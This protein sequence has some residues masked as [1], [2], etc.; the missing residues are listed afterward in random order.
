VS[1]AARGAVRLSWAAALHRIAPQ[2]GNKL[3]KAEAQA[4]KKF[5]EARNV[6]KLC[7]GAGWVD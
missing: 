6:H 3:R 1:D 7:F 4:H 2:I 5:K